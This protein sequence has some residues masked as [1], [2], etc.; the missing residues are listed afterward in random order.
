MHANMLNKDATYS[1]HYASYTSAVSL[2][3]RQRADVSI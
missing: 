1:K 2:W 3:A